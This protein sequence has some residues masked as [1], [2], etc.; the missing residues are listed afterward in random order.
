MADVDLIV[1]GHLAP[2]KMKFYAVGRFR[3]S[4]HEHTQ[5]VAAPML[6]SLFEIFG[7]QD[8][9]PA[10]HR[11]R[12]DAPVYRVPG[13]GFWFVTRQDDVKALF[14]DTEC[15]TADARAGAGFRPRPEGSYLRWM[16]DQGLFAL[17]L[18]Q[19]ARIRRLVSAAFTPRAVRR[20]DAQIRDVVEEFA[21]PLRRG[22]GE[23]IDLA[24]EYADPIPNA[25]IARIT[26]VPSEESPESPQKA[27]MT[28]GSV[29]CAP[30][31]AQDQA[32]CNGG[33]GSV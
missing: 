1:V 31:G 13:A 26:G 5:E 22:R 7:G 30:R 16:Q 19:H 21:Q 25:A 23:V 8:A 6:P 11:L 12:E 28:S 10:V 17:S 4:E 32:S 20:M 33:P 29:S 24:A 27:G 18:E 3:M 9:Y 14:R 15:V 2:G